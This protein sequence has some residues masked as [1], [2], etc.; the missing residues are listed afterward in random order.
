MVGCRKEYYPLFDRKSFELD[1]I[2]TMISNPSSPPWR[3][4]WSSYLKQDEFPDAWIRDLA[5]L[6]HLSSQ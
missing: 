6:W 1:R 3:A 2:S 5:S 4:R